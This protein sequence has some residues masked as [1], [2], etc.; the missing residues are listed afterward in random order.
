M[1]FFS[2][3]VVVLLIASPAIAAT[4]KWEE[5]DREEV[6]G[7]TPW[8]IKEILNHWEYKTLLQEIRDRAI[9]E[10]LVGEPVTVIDSLKIVTRTMEWQGSTICQP[11]DPRLQTKLRG[12]QACY[13]NG[14]CIGSDSA[15]LDRDPCLP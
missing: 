15:V 7:E 11:N 4:E 6:V 13:E 1:K 14:E 3:I 2:R 12:F 9:S 8:G 10:T 5:I